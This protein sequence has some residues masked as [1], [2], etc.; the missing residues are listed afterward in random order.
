MTGRS[1]RLYVMAL[2][3]HGLVRSENIELGRDADTGGQTLYMI[4]EA[5]ALAAHPAV[6]RVDLVTRL[7]EDK[8]VS[9]DYSA[10][11]EAIAENARIVRV[12]FG[13]RRYLKKENLWPY[14]DSLVDRLMREVRRMR[15]SPDVIHAHYADA[16]YVGSRLSR[17]L[18]VPL[19]FTGHSLGRV[20]RERLLDEGMSASVIEDRYHIARRIEGEEQALETASVVIA[21]TNQEVEE[22]YALYTYYQPGRMTVI[23]PGV[24]LARFGVADAELDLE[25]ARAVIEPFLKDVRKPMVLAIARA[26]VRKNLPTLVRAFGQTRGLRER[27]NLVVAAGSRTRLGELDAGA[28]RVI[29]QIMN[30]IDDFDLYGSV[31][32]PKHLRGDLAPA[33]YRLAA[34]SRGVF[35]NPALTEPFGL[36]LLEAAANGLPV[37]TTSDGGPPD[38]LRVC[39]NGELVDPLDADEM[40]RL[41]LDTITDEAEWSKK[42]EN[43]RRGVTEFSW[44]AHAERYVEVVGDVL[45]GNRPATLIAGRSRLPRMDRA[46]VSDLDGTLTGDDES[47]HKLL[48][49]IH[50]V[51]ESTAFGIAT[52]RSMEECREVLSGIPVRRLDFLLTDSGTEIRYG[53]PDA[54][55]DR[56][57]SGHIAHHWKPVE[58]RTALEEIPGIEPRPESESGVLRIACTVDPQSALSLGSLR[59]HLRQRGLRATILFDSATRMDVLPIRASPGLALRFLE[60]KLDLALDRTLVAGDSGNDADML[61]GSTLGVVVANHK[62]EIQHLRSAPRVYFA[63]APHAAGVLEGIDY[64]DFFGSIRVPQEEPE[65]RERGA[66]S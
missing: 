51:G 13:P 61:T 19:V 26:D 28:R 22:Q 41:I 39:R 16:G 56:T 6:E 34:R 66:R 53:W 55:L 14:L 17:I 1:G 48:D 10:P 35:V 60:F 4:E 30:E 64:Y 9:R 8:A 29:H 42:S 27:A 7:V 2:G 37:V 20:K 24:D 43:A 65:T 45:K 44:S 62:P 54:E 46:L 31:A 52:G 47:L 33:L 18:G 58:I 36:T 25:G 57:W 5:R 15:R 3:L 38:I 11:E 21:S 12:G 32:Y 63:R 49:R 50:E 59:K 40:G 23:P